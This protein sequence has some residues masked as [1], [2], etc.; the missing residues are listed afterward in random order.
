[1]QLREYQQKRAQVQQIL[2]A[3]IAMAQ[4][5][6]LNHQKEQLK[7]DLQDLSEEIFH[8]VVVGEFS[9]GKS[10]FIN[11]LMGR[12]VL[13]V[14]MKPTTAIISKIIYGEEPAYTLYFKDKNQP[15]QRLTEEEFLGIR[16]VPESKK[17][18][19]KVLN[20][21]VMK[22]LRRHKEKGEDT[23]DF[24]SLDYAQIAYPLSFC[25]DGVEVVDTPG[26]NDLNVGRIEITYNYLQHADAVIFILA[27]N[28]PLSASEVAFLQDHILQNQIRDIFF[29]VNFK[30]ELQSADEE[31]RVLQHIEHHLRSSI[32]GFTGKH[33]LF[34]VSSRGALYF[35]RRAN[36]E[37]LSPKKLAKTPATLE[38]T[39]FIELEKNL[40]Q[41][42]DEEKGR[43]KLQKYVA[44]V[45]ETIHELDKN[46]H[47]QQEIASHSTDEIRAK[48]EAM[49]PEFRRARYD[50]K[51][52]MDS[53]QR[54]LKR[55]AG[56]IEN[57][58]TL[59]I[60]DIYKAGLQAINNNTGEVT[61]QSLQHD[62]NVAVTAAEK[63]FIQKLKKMETD[64]LE[65]EG[66]KAQAQL[67]RIW[68]EVE[69]EYYKNT[70]ALTLAQQ[71]NL[72]IG[73]I[74][75][76]GVQHVEDI[77]A[78]R[79]LAGTALGGGTIGAGIAAAILGA[80][81][82]PVIGL[83]LLAAA[84]FGIFEDQDAKRREEARK[85]LAQRFSEQGPAIQNQ[86]MQAYTQ[87][88]DKLC[89]SI[90]DTITGRLDEME[91]QLKKILAQKENK[92]YKAD[93]EQKLL[94]EKEQIL[95]K[96]SQE[97]KACLY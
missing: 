46:L 11:A 79:V 80:S 26:T 22:K 20:N 45:Q 16:A 67:T 42:L 52:V 36:G 15:P 68:N 37:P 64:I 69:V 90:M 82:M 77:Q 30:D 29:V 23:Y 24:Q 88:V 57:N 93:Q 40:A 97:L 13:P 12:Q 41:F 87:E 89:S 86:V 61:A 84:V 65:R 6:G 50:A 48:S 35:R 27:A 19:D 74:S 44:R 72:T 28:Q 9:R 58:C 70:K 54:D 32:P 17:L 56:D 4:D 18:R 38:E 71:D 49:E 43:A 91:G 59:W 55:Y 63:E 3:L 94:L 21:P 25:R 51:K 5:L 92:E 34:L 14:N 8:L 96:L 7:Q 47:M 75:M 62:V 2:M 73:Q 76:Q 53:L 10:T 85:A 31:K 78:A 81:F 83:G 66:K 1:M 33:H 60:N 39:G 95:H